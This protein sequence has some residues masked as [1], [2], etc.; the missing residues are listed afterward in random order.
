MGQGAHQRSGG[1][2][3]RLRA[4]LNGQE[5]PVSLRPG[6]ELRLALENAGLGGGNTATPTFG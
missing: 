6:E 1:G 5:G 2:P 3:Q 4:T